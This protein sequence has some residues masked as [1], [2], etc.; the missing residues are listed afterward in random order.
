MK[1]NIL[2]KN[3]K[4]DKAITL[5]ALV[6]TIIVL[7]ILAGVTIV[8]LTG[9]NGLIT[10][11]ADAKKANE[12]ATDLEKIQLEVA[13]SYGLDKKIDIGQLNT[14]LKRINELKYNDKDIILEGDNINMIEELPA[15]VTV[16][17]CSFSIE[18][19]GKVFDLTQANLINSKIGEVVQGYSA[20]DLQWQVFYADAEE[21]YLISK[22]LAK[23]DWSIPLK[24]EKQ[25][26]DEEQYTYKGS[27]DVR[28]SLYGA[29]WNKMWLKRCSEDIL[30]NNESTRL[31]AKATAYMCDYNNWENYVIDPAN[32]AVGGPTIELLIASWN[33][34]QGK[35]VKLD[36]GDIGSYG[37]I[38]L[39][40][41]GLS[42]NY[43]LRKEICNGLYNIGL[44]Y[45]IISPTTGDSEW[46]LGALHCAT[47]DSAGRISVRHYYD[48]CR[49]QTYCLNSYIKNKC[50]W[51]YS[52]CKS[53]NIKIKTF[54]CIFLYVRASVFVFIVVNAVVR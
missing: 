12:K 20:A 34:S 33:K 2:T 9:D 47:N 32:Y 16:K 40:P 36:Y 50:K 21:T 43:P 17:K 1:S 5:I 18:E 10:K 8:T 19:N 42:I 11:A 39:K 3:I 49:C 52:Y 26:Q 35:N 29:K 31:N 48:K 37:I 38:A 27:E 7:L 30:N 44:W 14:N 4:N 13:G 23:E 53:L 15:E 28:K 45:F 41:D 24:R 22:N 6:I 46:C 51:R 54:L 25:S